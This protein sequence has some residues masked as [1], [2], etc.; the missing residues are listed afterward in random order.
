MCSICL[1]DARLHRLSTRCLRQKSSR[2]SS[3]KPF[4]APRRASR[5][6]ATW[7]GACLRWWQRLAPGTSGSETTSKRVCRRGTAR[8]LCSVSDDT[9]KGDAY[10]LL[11]GHSL[12]LGDA[13]EGKEEG[14]SETSG[15]DETDSGTDDALDLRRGEA[16]CQWSGLAGGHGCSLRDD[17]VEKPVGTRTQRDAHAT[18]TNGESLS[19]NDPGDWTPR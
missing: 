6:E 15:P 4:Q 3:A 8:R 16:D 10:L 7:S 18:E 12:G 11:D 2:W 9:G 14:Q 13:E 1:F 17:Q 5:G 19:A